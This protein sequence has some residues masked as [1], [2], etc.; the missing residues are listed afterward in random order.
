MDG[1]EAAQAEAQ[2]GAPVLHEAAALHRQN[3]E[4]EL[5]EIFFGGVG[6][7]QDA[8]SEAATRGYHRPEAKPVPDARRTA[9]WQHVKGILDAGIETA[10]AR[11][12]ATVV[13]DFPFFDRH[14][15]HCQPPTGCSLPSERHLALAPEESL[16]E[17]GWIF[18]VDGLGQDARLMLHGH[19]FNLW[20][21]RGE[22]GIKNRAD[23]LTSVNWRIAEKSTSQE[24]RQD[25][26][27]YPV[28]PVKGDIAWRK[29]YRQKQHSAVQWS[30]REWRG[31]NVGFP[32]A[33]LAPGRREPPA[34][35]RIKYAQIQTLLQLADEAEVVETY[36]KS[37]TNK[38]IRSHGQA[39]H[40]MDITPLL[41]RRPRPDLAPSNLAAAA[42]STPNAL[43]NSGSAQVLEDA[44]EAS[45]APGDS[46]WEEPNWE[47]LGLEVPAKAPRPFKI[48]FI[49]ANAN[50][51]STLKLK[52]EYKAIMASL[53]RNSRNFASERYTP[54]VKQ[55]PY[56]T[57]S[58]VME[59]V[60]R[61]HPSAL[62]FGLHSDEAKGI[63]LFRKTV[64]PEVMVPAIRAWNEHAR[65]KGHNEVRFRLQCEPKFGQCE[66]KFACSQQTR[67]SSFRA[68]PRL[69]VL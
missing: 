44:A 12:R 43:P 63:E 52:E 51:S 15:K 21:R 22:R 39:I 13:V 58:E 66:P 45:A 4:S 67:E 53:D 25:D 17:R 29:Y 24:W 62:Q 5:D 47:G 35:D 20:S 11:I 55:I 34:P 65:E 32:K 59:E 61:E 36:S 26:D 49:G 31:E 40:E 9:I 60:K 3:L 30:W 50:E 19:T 41:Q 48:L 37:G 64:Q 57:W 68:A 54:V 2:A 46:S 1:D 6:D 16:L 10:R 27:G 38:I 14:G 7:E 33:D 8:S 18:E 28:L 23:H 56:S 69:P 42:G